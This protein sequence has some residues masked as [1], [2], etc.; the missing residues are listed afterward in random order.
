MRKKAISYQ[1][2]SSDDQSQHSIER[3]EM[4][5]GSWARSN[6]VAIV[7]AF[8]DKGYSARTFD[9]PDVKSLFDFIKKNY[10][11]ID[12]LLV[13]ELTRFSRETGD[14][15]NMVKKIQ[16]TY[17]IR[18][19]SSSRGQV[20]DIYDSSSFLMMGLEFLL[21]N[22]ENI[23]RASDINGGIYA[24]KAIKGKWIHGGP[25]PFGYTKEGTGEHRRLQINESQ[26]VV[27][28]YIFTEYLKQVPV[29][30]IKRQARKMGLKRTSKSCIQEILMNPLYMSYQQVKPWKDQPGGL[31]PI[32]DLAP[33]IEPATWYQVQERLA[34]PKYSKTVVDH[35]P[36]RQV[37]RCYCQG[38]LSGAASTNKVGNK[39]L[40]YKCPKPRHLNLSAK[41]AHEQLQET[42]SLMSLP[43]YLLEAIRNESA[44]RL[45]ERMKENRQRL[46]AAKKELDQIEKSLYNVEQKFI[47][48]G[49]ISPETYQRWTR[50]LGSKRIAAGAAIDQYSRDEQAVWFLLENELDQ[51]SDL[52]SV[53]NNMTTTDKQELLRQV[54][55]DRLYY[56]S[57]TFRTPFVLAPFTH[58][59][60]TLKQKQLLIVDGMDYSEVSSPVMWR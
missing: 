42:L 11:Q 2:Y 28:R 24:A 23:K 25:P 47:T 15:I 51:L 57:H 38:P 58:N 40:Y 49:S 59:L 31:F 18:I 33:I 45:K 30:D 12:Y 29:T 54:F 16:Q 8:I 52:R 43:D 5:N 34:G 3:Q 19:V 32:K 44:A 1:R 9:R 17:N 21:G 60:L 26:A 4:L 7:D 50:D 14:A 36:L 55:D 41:K 37:L 39:Y 56:Q 35:L 13:S 27:I 22:T 48:E 6:D 10:R 53:Y 46:Q 20:Y